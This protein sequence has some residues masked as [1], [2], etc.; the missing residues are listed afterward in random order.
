MLHMPWPPQANWLVTVVWLC[1]VLSRPAGSRQSWVSCGRAA[2][3]TGIYPDDGWACK[4]LGGTVGVCVH[5]RKLSKAYLYI[6]GAS[7]D[8]F[9]VLVSGAY[10]LPF[11]VKFQFQRYAGSSYCSSAYQTPDAPQCPFVI[12]GRGIH[13]LLTSAFVR[14]YISSCA[15]RTHRVRR[16]VYSTLH[17]TTSIELLYTSDRTQS[18]DDCGEGD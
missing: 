8:F 1:S 16:R 18:L 3:I 14:C 13:N 9:E 15:C 6:Q 7:R 11:S 17:I 10:L 12:T 5:S 2:V 4:Y